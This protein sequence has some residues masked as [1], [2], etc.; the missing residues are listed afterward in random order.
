MREFKEQLRATKLSLER[1]L[2][3]KLNPKF[4]ILL[5]MVVHTTETI[6]RFLVGADGRTRHYRLY[7]TVSNGNMLKFG[8]IVY[9]EFLK[10]ASR[11]L[12]L[13][14]KVIRSW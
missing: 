3:T 8:K 2:K 13:N 9:A 1:R 11:K 10:K 4:P 14:S 6:N 12:S 7:D 5:W